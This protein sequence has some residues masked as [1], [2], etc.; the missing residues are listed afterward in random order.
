MRGLL[1]S[2]MSPPPELD[3]E[4]HDW[5]D[6]EHIPVRLALPGF[7][8]AARYRAVG[9]ATEYLVCYF[10]DDLAVLKTEAYDEIKRSPGA[11]TARMLDAVS[12]F[13]R[14]TCELVAEAG[15]TAAGDLLVVHAVDV[16]PGQGPEFETRYADAAAQL[17]ATGAYERMQLYRSFGDN[18]GG[19]FTHLALYEIGEDHDASTEAGERLAASVTIPSAVLGQAWW[20]YRAFHRAGPSA[21][22][23]S[24]DN[25]R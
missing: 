24:I 11:R 4:F 12:G 5:Y 6:N 8:S 20:V 14:F 15:S 7:G 22:A 1:F 10:I 21:L 19:P 13:T 3:A 16:A 23:D 9:E 17:F 18:V 25:P 2:Q